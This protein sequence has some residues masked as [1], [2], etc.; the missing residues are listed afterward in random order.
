MA[1]LHFRGV[2]RGREF[3]LTLRRLAEVKKTLGSGGDQS[4]LLFTDMPVT[5]NTGCLAS[6]LVPCLSLLPHS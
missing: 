2:R 1:V 3:Q 6:L 4:R 5:V